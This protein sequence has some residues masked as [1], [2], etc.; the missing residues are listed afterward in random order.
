MLGTQAPNHRDNQ[1]VRVVLCLL[2][3]GIHCILG[4]FGDGFLFIEGSWNRSARHRLL[5][6]ERIMNSDFGLQGWLGAGLR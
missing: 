3:P 1:Q 2:P 5:S 6:I 4:A